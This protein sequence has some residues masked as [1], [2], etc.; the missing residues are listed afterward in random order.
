MVRLIVPMA[1]TDKSLGSPYYQETLDGWD[2][3]FLKRGYPRKKLGDRIQTDI[4]YLEVVDFLSLKQLPDTEV[5]FYNPVIKIA[6][7]NW[8]DEL[9]EGLPNRTKTVIVDDSD[10]ENIITEE[11][12]KTWRE[13]QGGNINP[14]LI[15][16]FWYV[17]SNYGNYKG[18]CLKDSEL[19]IIHNSDGVVLI[20]NK[21]EFLVEE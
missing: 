20:N 21:P 16:G 2:I 10:P 3:R 12:V 19:V 8:D 14:V 6:E 13:W 18:A 5:L 4:E 11:Q 1:Y 7:A 9:P 15:E 17:N